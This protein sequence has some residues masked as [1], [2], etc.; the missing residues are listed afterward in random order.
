MKGAT[1]G[2]GVGSALALV[3]GTMLGV[4]ILLTPPLVVAASPSLWVY[5]GLWVLG[6]ITALAGA[7]AYAELGALFPERGGDVV[8]QR[9]AFGPALG[10]A[11]GLLTFGLAFSGSIAAMAVAVAEYQLR[12][13]VEAAG[14]TL[15]DAAVVPAAVVLVLLLTALNVLG[16]RWAARFQVVATAVPLALLVGLAVF[17]L[18]SAPSVAFSAPVDAVDPRALAGA[19][20]SVYFAYA[21][22]PAVAY[23]ASEVRDPGRTLS[24]GM[25]GGTLLV[26]AAYLVLCAA[27][28]RVLGADA[29][30]TAGEAGT[31]LASTLLG[32]WGAVGVA[33]T[34]AVAL[35]ASLNG[36]ILGGARVA[37]GVADQGGLPKI[38]A[39]EGVPVRALW[40]QAALS[41][42]LAATGSFSLILELTGVA[43]MVVGSATVA[44]LFVLRFRRPELARP[45]SAL[46]YPLLP[47]LYLL[48]S[49]VTVGVQL[50]TALQEGG[51]LL[52]VAGVLALGAL[53]LGWR[54]AARLGLTRL[55][56]QPGR[57]GDGP[58]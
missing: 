20:S 55:R 14:G 11:S 27:F 39:Q 41:C 54:V 37:A 29:L 43:M 53:V 17:G 56:Q 47:A 2:I 24:V 5:Y 25:V 35:L 44:G 19:F 32:P 36:T 26:T 6:G 52:P 13:L 18:V 34:V 12:T 30:A 31:A 4:G 49:T 46:G 15:P 16:I 22:W 33:G 3:V 8:F 51:W 42:A 28:V 9:E 58:A 21:G 40:V 50:Q 10:F 57:R 38:L 7:A 48:V 1:S 45:V 23:V